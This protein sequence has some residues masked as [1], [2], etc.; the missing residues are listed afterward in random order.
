MNNP[1]NYAVIGFPIHHSKSPRIHALFAEETAQ[2]MSYLAQE[3]RPENFTSAVNEFFEKGG[4]G[5]N[6]TLPLKELAWAFATNKTPRAQAAKA[7]NTLILQANGQI[8]GDNTD[9]VGLV[10]D[11][12]RNHGVNLE[13]KRLLILGAG[14]ATRGILLPLLDTKPKSITIANRTLEKALQLA[15]DF[16]NHCEACG[17]DALENQQFDVILNATSASLS[18]E[19]PPLP[20]NLLAENGIC[21]DLAY[22][23]QPTAF[24]RWG[25]AQHAYKS[26]DGLGMLVEQAAEAFFL[27]RGVRPCTHDVIDLLNAHR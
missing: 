23:N 18:D 26:V 5:L 9:G 15:H 20:E 19:L 17:F 12:T 24:V 21:Y 2:N 27:W 6:C 22:S 13:N 4:K 11:L 14:G 1:D 7:V 3:V 25:I 10:T 8:L 16:D